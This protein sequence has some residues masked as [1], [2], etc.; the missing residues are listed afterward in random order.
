ME[1]PNTWHSAPSPLFGRGECR[2]NAPPPSSVVLRSSPSLPSR[3]NASGH[4]PSAA[5]P[6][7][8]ALPVQ[9]V[10][11]LSQ[12]C[13]ASSGFACL[14]ALFPFPYSPHRSAMSFA[15]QPFPPSCPYAS[16]FPDS[17][18][19]S[20]LIRS[21]LSLR[22]AAVQFPIPRGRARRGSARRLLEDHMAISARGSFG[23]SCPAPSGFA[24]RRSQSSSGADNAAGPG[25]SGPAPTPDGDARREG[26]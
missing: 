25:P 19:K 21:R 3:S 23:P 4:Q 17:A 2:P 10:S 1:L 24:A 15:S 9:L 16:P 5:Q 11:C 14:P 7:H 18:R 20:G 13:L 6:A 26:L 12:P 22:S 8:V